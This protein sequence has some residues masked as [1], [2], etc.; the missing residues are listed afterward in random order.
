MDNRVL[1]DAFKKIIFVVLSYIPLGLA[2]GIALAEAGLTPFQTTALAFLA[3]TGA[4]QFA[5][6]SMIVQGASV[7][8]IW[9][10]VFFLNLRM[11]LQTSTLLPYV[12]DRPL[13]FLLV[14]AQATTD[15]AYG[16]NIYQF[17]NNPHWSSRKALTAAIMAWVAWALSCGL[18]AY[19]GSV[20]SV[21][22]VIVNYVLIAMF[23]SM[24]IDQLVSRTHLIA[25]LVAMVLTAL[26]QALFDHS[27]SIVAA[28]LLGALVG[29]AL[30][31]RESSKGGA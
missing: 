3:Y 13:P 4:G 27:L 17:N 20:I 25:A 16:I 6:A 24:T 21:P 7:W 29:F 1:N 22:T 5:A 18:G 30:E 11:S 12:N 19:I 2:C 26:F 10:M 14:F 9:T 8:T 15:E 23:I 28:T 31:S